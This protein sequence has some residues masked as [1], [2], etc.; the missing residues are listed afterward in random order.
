MLYDTRQ[1]KF[2]C[3]LS[4]GAA[5]ID[6]F[7]LII[8]ALGELAQQESQSTDFPECQMFPLTCYNIGSFEIHC[9]I[10]PRT[11]HGTI[12]PFSILLSHDE[13]TP[14]WIGPSP[15]ERDDNQTSTLPVSLPSSSHS[16]WVDSHNGKRVALTHFLRLGRFFSLS[17]SERRLQ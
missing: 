16:L 7:K 4:T 15:S 8:A 6:K 1:W 14:W 9:D 13:H 11:K 12:S 10:Y 17:L 3:F 2:Y 5:R